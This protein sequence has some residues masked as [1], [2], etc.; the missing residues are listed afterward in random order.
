MAVHQCVRFSNDPR[1][2]HERAVQ[3]ISKYLSETTTRGIIYYTD[4]T[5]G[6]ECYVDSDFS[7][8][9]DREDGQ[10]AK[11]VLS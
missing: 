8:G 2:I 11:N 7:G 1:L 9:W 4:K 10:R 5:Q 6:T 3:K